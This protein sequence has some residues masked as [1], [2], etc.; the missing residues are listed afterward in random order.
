MGSITWT[1]YPDDTARRENRDGVKRHGQEWS[2]GPMAGTRWG[3]PFDGGPAVLIHT[4]SPVK[5]LPANYAI[6][7]EAV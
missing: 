4:R 7:G 2:P 1:E 6:Q 5:G 3:I